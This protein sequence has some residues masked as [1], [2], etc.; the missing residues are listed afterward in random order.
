MEEILKETKDI[1]EEICE[2]YGYDSEDKEGNDSLKTVLLKAIPAMLK[3]TK[4]KE[5]QIF[6]KML[7]HT[8]IVITENITREGLDKLKEQ[9]I[10]NINPH[11][12]NDNTQKSEL[13]GAYG[14]KVGD[15]AYVSEPIIDENMQ[16]IGKKSFIYIQKVQEKQK[17]FL[18]T[19]INVPHLLH[20][21]G[22]A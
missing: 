13:M 9:Y 6:Y 4:P 2:K 3:N 20:E 5:I 10:G 22:H 1:V 17:E 8:P 16:V 7:R 12:V 21:L 19:D 15:G 11:I 18:G 14:K